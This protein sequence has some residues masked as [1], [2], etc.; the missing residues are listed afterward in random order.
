MASAESAESGPVAACG[1]Y[2]GA[3]PSFRKKRCPGCAENIKATWCAVRRCCLDA[4]RATCVECPDYSDDPRRCTKFNH[5]IS[6]LIGWVLNSDRAR[7]IAR[8][9]EVGRE[10]YAKEMEETNRC[11]LPRK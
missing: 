10:A 6:R 4:K 5:W 11:T 7:C 8:I 2:C 1:L 9:R 3:C